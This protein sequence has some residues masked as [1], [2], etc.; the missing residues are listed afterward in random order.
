MFVYK[1]RATQ[2]NKNE[3]I[4]TKKIK[5]LGNRINQD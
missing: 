2:N 3:G 4:N 5:I 1:R